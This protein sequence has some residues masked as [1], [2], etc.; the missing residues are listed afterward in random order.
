M[1][2]FWRAEQYQ[3]RG[4]PTTWDWL[5]LNLILN[6]EWQNL[7]CSSIVPAGTKVIEFYV[8]IA[9]TNQGWGEFK[10]RKKGNLN[11]YNVD[12]LYVIKSGNTFGKMRVPCNAN[13]VVEYFGDPTI[14]TVTITIT[15]WW[16]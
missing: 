6:G 4:D 8:E 9:A 11:N 10:M 5:K 2:N 7:D 14:S 3:D 13:R 1:W 15:G 16:I 12:G